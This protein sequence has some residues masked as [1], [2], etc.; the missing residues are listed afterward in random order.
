MKTPEHQPKEFSL[1]AE[2]VGA[3]EESSAGENTDRF[4]FRQSTEQS[5][6]GGSRGI[7]GYP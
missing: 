3:L 4:V 7:E 5:P 6:K 2:A 1:Y